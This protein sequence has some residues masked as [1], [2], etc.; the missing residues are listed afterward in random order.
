VENVLES[1]LE[2]ADRMRAGGLTGC[3]VERISLEDVE[4]GSPTLAQVRFV[5]ATLR[6]AGLDGMSARDV[7]FTG[8]QLRGAR[9][10]RALWRS[11]NLVRSEAIEVS[12]AGALLDRVGFYDTRMSNASFAR[13]RL[14]DVTFQG[15]DLMGADFS[16]TVL[17]RCRF[18]DPKMGAASLNRASFRRSFL[19]DVNL[20]GA[21]LYGADLSDAVFLQCDLTGVVLSQANVEG[22]RF[23]ACQLDPD[24]M[25]DR[26][27]MT[28]RRDFG[29]MAQEMREALD[30]YSREELMDLVTHLARV[31]VV[32]GNAPVALEEAPPPPAGMSELSGLSFAQLVLHLQMHLPHDELRRLRV[33]GPDVWVERGDRQVTLTTSA[34]DEPLEEPPDNDIIGA[35]DDQLLGRRRSASPP[36]A[37]GP[38]SEPAEWDAPPPATHREAGQIP[39]P[40]T[41]LRGDAERPQPPA[42]QPH[43][44]SEPDASEDIGESSDRFSMLELD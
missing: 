11:V 23:I 17:T 35:H 1:P 8:C 33:S 5:Q 26:S 6:G 36:A 30:Q 42:P 25:Q 16:D 13:A 14:H 9:M 12:F 29:L 40:S 37:G 44:E 24:F 28:E 34:G 31:F 15:A 32:E 21:V 43:T 39:R 18:E 2:V 41:G 19:T 22:A 20:S 38:P 4:L 3:V 27:P 10:A 7:S